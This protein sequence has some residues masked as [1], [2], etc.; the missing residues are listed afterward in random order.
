MAFRGSSDK[1]YTL[2][3]GNFLKLVQLFAKFD[4]VM[5]NHVQQVITGKI[6]DHYRGKNIQ[7]ELIELIAKKVNDTIVQRVN[8]TVYF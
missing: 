8:E 7:N 5:Q 2:H 3:N 1:L 6:S 4:P